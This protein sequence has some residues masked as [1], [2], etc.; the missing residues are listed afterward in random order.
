MSVVLDVEET[1]AREAAAEI[2]TALQQLVP[3]GRQLVMI[4]QV[5]ERRDTMRES[6]ELCVRH[7]R[8]LVRPFK[9]L[10]ELPS[11]NV[12]QRTVRIEGPAQGIVR[13]QVD[14]LLEVRDRLVETAL[15]GQ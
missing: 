12:C 15:I 8:G 13:A 10:I 3:G 7:A 2:R 14:S 6:P 4:L 9:G 1:P 5:P 11:E